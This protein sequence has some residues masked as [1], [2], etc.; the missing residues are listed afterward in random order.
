MQHQTDG[1]LVAQARSGNKRAFGEL[2]ERYQRMAMQ[3]AVKMVRQE[4][5]ARDLVQEAFLA[6]YLSLAQLKDAERF[7]NWLYSIVLNVCRSYLRD[8]KTIT[9]SLEAL[10]GGMPS[11]LLALSNTALDPQ[12]IVEERELHGVL[13]DAVQQLAPKERA[14]TLLFYYDQ[15][16]IYEIATLLD[17]SQSAVKSRLFQARKRLRASLLAGHTRPHTVQHGQR[18]KIMVRMHIEGVRR[19][20][21][22]NDLYLITL[23]DETGSQLLNISIGQQ[24]A[25]V[26]VM[27]L[28]QITTPRPLTLHFMANTL[29]ATQVTLEEVRIEGLLLSPVP[30]F[31]A[32][33][34][35]RNG[36]VVQEIDV[37]PSDALGLAA[38]LNSPISVAEEL[39]NTDVL[40]AEV[41][42]QQRVGVI[43]VD[44][45]TPE[46]HFAE[47]IF[48][49]AGIVL[50]AGK[51]LRLGLNKARAR[52][53]L[54]R[55]VKSFLQGIPQAPN[56]QAGERAKWAY[57]RYVLGEDFAQYMRKKVETR[58]LDPFLWTP[59][60]Q[61]EDG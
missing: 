19:N 25:Y 28:Q 60:R 51:K 33:A 15:L 27:A 30:V 55:E 12:E 31:T 49:Q 23:L 52:E 21:L 8:Q 2:L 11:D 46:E 36:D 37:R 4:E 61:A 10:L 29:K 7:R 24:E 47:T 26:I 18:S 45:K 39:F 53:D 17:I 32:V 42:P 57:F 40:P 13:L 5:L 16:S 41:F 54:V 35:L 38:L 34:R 1:E 43:L 3:I 22:R 44:G 59:L 6:A 14:V 48:A 9:F 58:D 56:E 50:P 20:F